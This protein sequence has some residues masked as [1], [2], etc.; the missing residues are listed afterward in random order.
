MSGVSCSPSI[1]P[2]LLWAQLM[3]C[4]QAPFKEDPL[5]RC[6]EA[7]KAGS[8]FF[9]WAILLRYFWV[10]LLPNSPHVSFWPCPTWRH[11]LDSHP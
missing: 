3:G 6:S 4:I 2:A 5:S 11:M 7:L 8:P 9:C 10:L 1:L